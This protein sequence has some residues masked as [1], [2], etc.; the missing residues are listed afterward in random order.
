MAWITTD[1]TNLS[2]GAKADW[3][4]LATADQITPL[5]AHVRDTGNRSQDNLCPR[6]NTTDTPLDTIEPATLGT[7]VAGAGKLTVS[8]TPHVTDPGDYC[9][10][11]LAS[12]TTIAAFNTGIIRK[13]VDVN[14]TE[15]V[16][17]GL[18]P[19]TLHYVREVDV[20]TS[21]QNSALST[22]VSGIPT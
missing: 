16:L 22:Q 1:W 8:I 7:P 2:D 9:R 21:G 5:N 12:T 19:G 10:V 4:E 18:T 3:E 14:A 17:T 11:F 20:D 13:I 15:A 6:Q